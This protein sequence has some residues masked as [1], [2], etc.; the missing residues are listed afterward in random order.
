M[1]IFSKTVE[2][3][4]A[5]IDANQHLR[6]SAY[7]DLCAH[8]RIEWL[9]DAGFGPEAFQ[10]LGFGPVLFRE[11]TEYR[12]EVHLGERITIRLSLAAASPDNG[13]WTFRHELYKP[14]GQLAAIHEVTGAWMSLAA[15]KLI[16]P[17]GELQPLLADLAHSSDFVPL[18]QPVYK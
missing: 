4:W 15:R 7:A 12:R 11:S 6:H 3:R 8:S 1:S 9:Q 14:D 5:D 18:P 2:I 13:R 16:P 17:P 10:R